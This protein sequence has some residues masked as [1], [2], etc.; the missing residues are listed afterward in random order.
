MSNKLDARHEEEETATLRDQ[1]AMAAL[2]ET[3][4]QFSASTTSDVDEIGK[5]R[6]YSGPMA[7]L[8]AICAY[9]MADAMMEARKK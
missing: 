7:G 2:S 5:K 8:V 9:E 3:S 1:F 6:K 4:R